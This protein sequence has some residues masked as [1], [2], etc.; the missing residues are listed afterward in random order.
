ME[1][2]RLAARN[3]AKAHLSALCKYGV[4]IALYVFV[5]C[6][7]P[8]YTRPRPCQW[9]KIIH[10]LESWRALFFFPSLPPPWLNPGQG[11]TVITSHVPDGG[12]T[13]TTNR[14]KREKSRRGN[15]AIWF[16]RS[17]SSCPLCCSSW[18]AEHAP[19]RIL[20]RLQ[21]QPE[22]SIILHAVTGCYRPG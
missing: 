15:S 21:S 2:L 6:A 8:N 12:A 13:P 19:A 20:G 11:N 5:G 22:D 3:G 14:A 9:R 18:S 4:S 10:E 16:K 17:G 7:W 1:L